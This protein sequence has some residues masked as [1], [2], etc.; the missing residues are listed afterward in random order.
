MY[1]VTVGEGRE[2]GC[3]ADRWARS[4]RLRV[5]EQSGP[6]RV[7][8]SSSSSSAPPPDEPG[9]GHDARSD[10][11]PPRTRLIVGLGASAGGLDAFKTFFATMPPD[12]GIAFVLVQH[13]D[14]DR[15]SSLPA[16]VGGYTAMPVLAAEA[17]MAIRPDHVYVIPPN[18]ILRVDGGVLQLDRPAP[19]AARRVLINTFLTSLAEDQGEA[20]VGVILSGYGS[21]GALGIASIKEHGGLTL[22]Q[23]EFDHHAKSGMPQSAA[24]GGFVD[25]VLAVE[26]MAAALLN[27]RQHRTAFDSDKDGDGIRQDIPGQL[28]TI[29]AVLHGR[30]GR[31]FS[32]YKSG[33]LMRRIQ[34]RMSVLQTGDVAAYIAQLRTSPNEAELL[35]RELLISV[36][37][38]FRDPEAFE[39]LEAK[40]LAKL[41]PEE[42][43]SVDP[44]RV[45]V[46][47]CATGEEAYSVAIL[48]KEASARSG[49]RRPVQIF[50][51]DVDERALE[52]ARAGLYPG[53]IADDLSPERLERNFIKEDGSYRVT[54]ELREMCLFSAH[55][56]VKDPPFSK[57]DLIACR[58]LMIYFEPALQQRV[59]TT[60]H[61]ALKPQGHLFL[62]PSESVSAQSRLF[63][64]VD[65][66]RRLYAKRDTAAFPTLALS[67]LTGGAPAVKRAPAPAG[68][69]IERRAAR[70]IAPYAPAYLVVDRNHDVLRFSGATAKFL[71]PNGVASLN[72]FN[73]LHTELRAAVRTALKHVAT[74]GEAAVQDALNFKTDDRYDAVNLIVEP[75]ADS[76]AGTL[77][78][79]AF[80]QVGRGSSAAG[81]AAGRGHPDEEGDNAALNREL[82]TTRER[83]RIVSEELEAAN[84]ELQSSN[85]EYLSVNEELQSTNE[86]LETSKEELQS[87]NEELQTINAELGNRND[88]LLRSNSD[89]N[90]LFDS[91]SI[92][93]LFLDNELRIRRFTPGLLEIFKVREGDEGRPIGDIVTRLTRDG[94]ADNVKQVLRTLTPLER[95]VA[96]EDGASYLMQVRPYRGLDNVIDGAVVAF[97]DISERKQS[98]QVRAQLAAIVASSQDAIVS[99]DLE[100]V[101][102][103]WN[104]GAE[105][106]YGFPSSEAIGRPIAELLDGALPDGWP[107]I[108]ARLREGERIEQFDSVRVSKA[109]RS[110]DVSLSISP[111]VDTAGSI[112]GASAVARD[113]SERKAADAQTALLLGELDHRVKNILQIV[114]AVIWQT[115]RSNPDPATFATEVEGRI[116]AIAKAHSL[117]TQAGGGVMSLRALIDT[118]LAPYRGALGEGAGGVE[119]SGPDIRLAPKSG[120]SLA[121]AV[122]ELASNAAKYGALST[123]AGTL[124]VA[125]GIGG[126]GGRP[127]LTLSWIE[128]EG[129]AVQ[130]P[131]RRGFGTMLIERTL[132]HELDA[133]VTREFLPQG[134]RCT[135]VIPLTKEVGELQFPPD[136]RA[137]Q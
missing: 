6:R 87:L 2:T 108:L 15:D 94:L 85:E 118:E 22:G 121:M 71:E 26:D 32:Q 127:T 8:T 73:L 83:L 31:D 19:A 102:D 44:I 137:A 13:L 59:F 63:D 40:V 131:T 5:R 24:S 42:R 129:P 28:A 76:D 107:Q 29:C 67:R 86:E 91:T 43:P 52:V 58:N 46:A 72:L 95:E 55:D 96:V 61:Y 11:R 16:I 23:A 93:T 65:K 66:R 45:W 36:T 10:G 39:A 81:E 115:L 98:E 111:V 3:L 119:V 74:T 33:T 41:S 82:T 84:E 117:L 106:L 136:V 30:L 97:V 75:L 12:S 51:T 123:A 64:A 79:V 27:Y 89:L 134:L 112:I 110:I 7:V 35:F 124:R 90:N 128:A 14:P 4:A 92:A 21:D 126:E 109:G 135:F 57:L 17:G 37:R 103:S 50:A 113:I 120:M 38:F 105:Q 18:A 133:T 132:T 47:G 25:H 125:W 49:R 80:Q 68:D 78:V 77:F 101:I 114:S 122:H 1:F 20:A 62:G 69:E 53:A 56:L 60:F 54:K 99:H 100:G 70:A 9:A 88:S 48:L 116:Q 130:A 34:R 104:A